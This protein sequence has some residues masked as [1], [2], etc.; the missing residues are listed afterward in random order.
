MSK[1]LS[2]EPFRYS[3][4]PFITI[5][6]IRELSEKLCITH[7]FTK[8]PNFLKKI[9]ELS[10]RDLKKLTLFDTQERIRSDFFE[11]NRMK[12]STSLPLFHLIIY[13]IECRMSVDEIVADLKC[14]ITHTSKREM[15]IMCREYMRLSYPIYAIQM[16]RAF[17]EFSYGIEKYSISLKSENDIITDISISPTNSWNSLNLVQI[18]GLDIEGTVKWCLSAFSTC[19]NLAA[20]SDRKKT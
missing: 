12:F 13:M 14:K 19:I 4:Q 3:I 11:Y 15:S 2:R 1:F 7:I 6:I 5:Q 20:L 8:F 10:I 9:Q 18:D 17:T 16:N